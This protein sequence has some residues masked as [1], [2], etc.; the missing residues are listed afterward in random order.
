[1]V[2]KDGSLNFICFS[3]SGRSVFWRQKIICKDL[4]Y[5]KEMMIEDSSITYREAVLLALSGDILTG[6]D[7]PANRYYFFLYSLESWFGY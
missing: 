3:G 4:P 5:I 1:M 7:C 2:R 6:C